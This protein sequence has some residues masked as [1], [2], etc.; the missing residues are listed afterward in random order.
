MG[1]FNSQVGQRTQGEESAVG[2]YAY[3]RRNWRGE[4]LVQFCLEN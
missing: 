1:D 4:K 3:G 2:Q